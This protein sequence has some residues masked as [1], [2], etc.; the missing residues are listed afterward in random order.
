MYFSFRG[1]L[2][3]LDPRRKLRLSLDDCNLILGALH[4]W[5]TNGCPVQ[6]LVDVDRLFDRVEA[7]LYR[8]LPPDS[9]FWES[10]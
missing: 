1:L 6:R 8:L 5:K 10:Y 7:E 4:N 3:K 2:E 9:P